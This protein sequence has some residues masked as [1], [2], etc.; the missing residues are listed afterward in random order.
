MCGIVGAFR[1]TGDVLSGLVEGLR[2]LEYRGY[3]SVGVGVIQ[4]GRIR[5][6]KR[7]GR[8]AELEKVLAAS[9]LEG[10]SIGIGHSRWATHGPPNDVNAHPHLGSRGRVALVHNGIIENFETL[11][12]E[13]VAGGIAMVSDTDTEV[14]AHLIEAELERTDR[15]ADAVRRAM[16]RVEGYYAIAVLASHPTPQLVC[17]REGPPLCVAVTDEAAYL[18]SDPLAILPHCRAIVFLEDGDVADLAPGRLQIHDARGSLVERAAKH[19][20]WDS[21]TATKGGYEHFMLKE[22]HEQPEV[23]ARTLFERVQPNASDVELEG[24]AFTDDVLRDVSRLQV[25]ACGTALHAGMVIR[26]L[27]EGLA[28]VPVDFDYASEFRYRRPILTPG[29]MVLGISQSGETADT[30]AAMRLATELGARPITICNSLGS[31]M[32]REAESTILTNAG[33]EIGVASTKAFVSMLVAGYL[34][35]VRWGRA[36]GVLSKSEGRALLGDLERLRPALTHV[37]SPEFVAR[38][39][40]V[41]KAHQGARGFLFLG[42]GINFPVALEG[43]LKLKE[44]AYVH[45]EG[46]AAGEMKHGPIALIDPELS[47]LVI[48]PSDGTSEK[49]RANVEQVRARGGPVIV[50]GSDE[51]SLA[52]AENPIEIPEVGPWLSPILNVVPLQ[53]FAYFFAA[54]RG[55]DIDKPRNL[56]KSVTVE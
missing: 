46:Y 23:V 8:I 56:A 42:R 39:Q 48:A 49:V 51:R 35:A 36:R 38:V 31:T 18:G 29:S 44:I 21:E 27:V 28:R 11:R 2:V 3:D 1:H 30:L 20:E 50:I 6:V 32:V 24:A 12:D 5:A 22:I 14:L 10:V 43:A 13:L 25:L 19:I 9:D 17:A 16:D 15:L 45:A 53:L 34:L 41:A 40:R 55:Y 33:P 54:A 47:T 52:L 7:A 4:H 26:Y 37:L